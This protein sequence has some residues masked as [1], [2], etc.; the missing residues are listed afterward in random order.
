MVARRA[1]I[2]LTAAA[3]IMMIV[4]GVQYAIQTT[5]E[6]RVAECQ[7]RIN[8][9]IVRVVKQRGQLS[10]ADRAANRRLLVA[11]TKAKSVDDVRR[12]EIAYLATQRRLDAQRRATPFPA[13]PT[14]GCA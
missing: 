7:A 2:L 3:F 9:A 11:M 4:I 5:H 10:D 13:V 6:R 8:T 1:Q 12:A 14:G